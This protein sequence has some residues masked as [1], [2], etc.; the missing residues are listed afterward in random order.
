MWELQAFP[1]VVGLLIIQTMLCIGEGEL[2]AGVCMED[3]TDVWLLGNFRV[4]SWRILKGNAL[5]R[6]S[7]SVPLGRI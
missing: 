3:H 2:Q 1:S 6:S 7:A 5:G 4:I